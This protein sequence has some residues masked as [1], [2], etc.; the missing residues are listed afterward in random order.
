LPA[1]PLDRTSA[2]Y[3]SFTVF[4][5]TGFGDVRPVSNGAR[6][7]VSAE[8]ACSLALLGV[9]VARVTRDVVR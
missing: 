5:T 9:A 7:L 4:T 2:I 8:M 6:A 3:L 1:R